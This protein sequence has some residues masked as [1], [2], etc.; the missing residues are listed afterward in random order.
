MEFLRSLTPEMVAGA[1]VGLATIGVVI[2]GLV[3]GW[4]Q[5]Q[6]NIKANEKVTTSAGPMATAISMSWDKDQVERALQALEQMAEALTI[7][8]KYS[9]AI[10]KSQGIL[11]DS[12]QHTTQEKLADILERLDHAEVQ[13]HRPRRR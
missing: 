2:R 1:L 7:Q 3:L 11:S 13:Q 10:A 5:A 4:Y 12:F 8:L 6:I 9:E